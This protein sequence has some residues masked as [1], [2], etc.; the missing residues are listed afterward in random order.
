MME[1]FLNNLPKY[2]NSLFKPIFVVL[3]FNTKEFAMRAA[4]SIQ[5][6]KRLSALTILIAVVMLIVGIV[7]LA[8][9]MSRNVSQ[10]QMISQLQRQISEYQATNQAL[11]QRQA[12][13]TPIVIVA[14]MGVV[15]VRSLVKR[16]GAVTALD[17]LD[18]SVHSK[19]F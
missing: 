11:A 13:A 19:K 1:V 17:G 18:L 6:K 14:T 16:F 9:S 10:T 4:R 5:E 12:E 7:L 8:T 3:K 2:N 15:E